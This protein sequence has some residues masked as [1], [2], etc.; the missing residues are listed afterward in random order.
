VTPHERLAA[1]LAPDVLAVIEEL[2][3]DRIAAELARRDRELS[4]TNGSPWLTLD[5]AAERLHCSPDAVRMR[6]NRGRLES[7]HQGARR[8]ISAASIERL[9]GEA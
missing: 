2:V 8:Y 9:G 4:A 5:Q 3:A 1:V 7:R 6:A